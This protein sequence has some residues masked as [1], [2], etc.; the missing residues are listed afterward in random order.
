MKQD[1]NVVEIDIAKRVFYLVGRDLFS[2]CLT[3]A[4]PTKAPKH[5]YNLF[6]I[7]RPLQDEP[8]SSRSSL[9]LL[10]I[11]ARLER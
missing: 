5:F 2:G 9:D 10:G 8:D 1:I 6:R 11:D 3:P 7:S 4:H